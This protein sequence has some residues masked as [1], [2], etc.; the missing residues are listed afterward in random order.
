MD[1]EEE[2]KIENDVLVDSVTQLKK[3]GFDDIENID[4]IERK[5]KKENVDNDETNQSNDLMNSDSNK[6]ISFKEIKSVSTSAEC[7]TLA[8]LSSDRQTPVLEALRGRLINIE[9]SCKY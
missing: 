1:K 2:Q 4:S 7:T 8:S 5:R 6:T 3:R 9:R